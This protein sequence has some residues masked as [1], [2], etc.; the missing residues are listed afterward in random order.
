MGWGGGESFE[1]FYISMMIQSLMVK[2]YTQCFY[3]NDYL[4]V[5][6]ISTE[7]KEL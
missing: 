2:C 4:L 7:R 5:C 3:I 6:K 1:T